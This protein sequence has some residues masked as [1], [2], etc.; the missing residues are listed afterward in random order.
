M[1]DLIKKTQEAW[2]AAKSAAQRRCVEQGD[3]EMA[4]KLSACQ[5]FSGSES[6]EEMISLMFSPRGAEFLTT[7]G[8][9]SL[10]VFR[11][12]KPFNPERF[13]VYIDSGEITLTEPRRAFLVGNTTAVLNYRET[14]SNRVVLMHGAKATVIGDG[15]SVVHIEA[16]ESSQVS[17]IKQGDSVV[18]C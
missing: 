10:D 7:Y 14:A 13:G 12:Y 15:F 9:P 11:Q 16:D 2:R 6:L 17:I 4:E 18:L 3:S 5:M 8:F 1:E